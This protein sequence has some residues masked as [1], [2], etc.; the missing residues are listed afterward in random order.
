[1]AIKFVDACRQLLHF[2]LGPFYRAMT[3]L[4][5]READIDMLS[6]ENE[7]RLLEP[8]QAEKL[9]GLGFIADH[10]LTV[11]NA[12]HIRTYAAAV[13]RCWVLRRLRSI[14]TVAG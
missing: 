13:V 10:L 4:Y 12:S 8:E 6:I 9:G 11:R 5:D 7:M 3:T 1:M 14:S 2:A